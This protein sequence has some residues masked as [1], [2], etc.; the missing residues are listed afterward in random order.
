MRSSFIATG[1]IRLQ[2]FSKMIHKYFSKILKKYLFLKYLP[3]T[4]SN[5]VINSR[6]VQI[7]SLHILKSLHSNSC[8]VNL[9]RFLRKVK[10]KIVKNCW[11]MNNRHTFS[12]ILRKLLSRDALV[13]WPWL[14][15]CNNSTKTTFEITDRNIV[16]YR[17]P[18]NHE[19]SRKTSK[20][21]KN[22]PKWDEQ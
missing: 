2:S 5:S 4:A 20:N 9:G 7:A 8:F 13:K 12:H 16:T 21:G 11:K 1:S 3:R 15:F 6:Q 19:K 10:S 14:W 18:Q 17:S 22:W